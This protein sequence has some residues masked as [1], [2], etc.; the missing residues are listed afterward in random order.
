MSKS[1][2]ENLSGGVG[3]GSGLHKSTVL[4]T[5]AE[6]KDLVANP[7]ELVPAPGVGKCIWPIS[8]FIQ[9][10]FGTT[11]YGPTSLA[12]IHVLVGDFAIYNLEGLNNVLN[13]TDDGIFTLAFEADADVSVFA[14]LPLLFKNISGDNL[15]DGN[16][17]LTVTVL[18]KTINLS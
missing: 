17:T 1:T 6:L 3:V 5:A 13:K 4:I 7:V 15:T 10:S 12:Q 9:Y 14:N 11:P 16:G 2:L 18:Y 8:A